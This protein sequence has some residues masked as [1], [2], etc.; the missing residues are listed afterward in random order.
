MPADWQITDGN[1]SASI[2]V[3]AGTM[4]GQV[5]VQAENGCGLSAITSINVIPFASVPAVPVDFSGEL[6]PCAG[7]T[8]TY[9][10]T[11]PTAN[12]VY[13][14]LFPATWVVQSQT[15]TAITVAATSEA[16]TISLSAVNGCGA[17]IA[18]SKAVTPYDGVPTFLSEI[19]GPPQICSGETEVTYRIDPA[20]G[21]DTYFWSVPSGWSIE[22]GQG[23][24]TIKV[25]PGTSGGQITV[26][27]ENT[28]G[29]SVV[30]VRNEVISP[31]AP[32]APTAITGT[33]K[34]CA[35]Q[36]PVTFTAA[37]T[38]NA[39]SYIWTYPADWQ[40]VGAADE[41]T[42]TFTIGSASGE[43]TVKAKNS[44]GASAAT[45]YFVAVVPGKLAAGAIIGP[46]EVCGANNVHTYF[47]TPVT[48]AINYKWTLPAGWDFVSAPNG[49]SVQ[50]RVGG[51]GTIALA[52]ENEC[53][54]GAA[55][56]HS[57]R[58]STAPPASPAA[59]IAG[60]G[61]LNPCEGQTGLTYSVA[62]VA[63]ATSYVWSVP[64]GWTFTGQGSSTI[65]VTSGTGSGQIR[66]QAIN[67]CLPSNPAISLTVSAFGTAPAQ[68]QAVVGES[69]PC[70]GST[71]VIYSVS[72]PVPGIS[73]VWQV[74]AN[75]T[76]T[77]GLGSSQITVTVG[78][79]AGAVSVTASNGCGT[80][81]ATS[82][83]VIPTTG[84]PAIPGN[85]E[86]LKDVC[87]GGVL[88]YKVPASADISNY[89]WSVPLGW[90]I[91]GGSGTNEI[92]VSFKVARTGVIRLVATN[93]CNLAT[94]KELSVVASPVKSDAAPVITGPE[95]LCEGNTYT[96]KVN[97]VANATQY[98]W[99]IPADWEEVSGQG[100]NT[101]VVKIGSSS[102]SVYVLKA[103]AS[104]GCGGSE[105]AVFNTRVFPPGLLSV[106]AVSGPGAVC[107]L[108]DPV[109]FTVPSVPLAATYA[110][111]FPAGWQPVS[112]LNSNT[113]VIIPGTSSGAVTVHVSNPCNVA[114]V[115][116]TQQVT[117][118]G[119][120]PPAPGAILASA[121]ASNPCVAQTNL[122]YSITAIA[123]TTAYEWRY[124]A[125][126]N[127][128]SGGTS[129]STSITLTAGSMVG[130]IAVRAKNECGW[131]GWRTY[132]V[133]PASSVPAT[134]AAIS[135]VQ[136][137]CAGATITY[138]VD[139]PVAQVVYSWSYPA[140]W[141]L[142]SGEGTSEAVFTVGTTSGNVSVTASN[143]CGLSPGAAMLPVAPRAGKPV[144]AGPINGD[145]T[146]CAGI[147]R[148]YAVTPVSAADSYEWS[149]PAGWG[150]VGDDTSS[151]ITVTVGGTSGLISVRGKNSCGVGDALTMAV[152][153]V[154]AIPEAPVGITG[155][156]QVC[157]TD[158]TAIFKVS[159]PVAGTTYTWSVP[160]SW[161]IT[162]S[163]GSST[164]TAEIGDTGEV[165]VI[166]SNVCGANNTPATLH[167]T[168][169]TAAPVAAGS[170]GG[171][172]N[173][174]ADNT[175][176][177]YTVPPVNGATSYEWTLPA[178]WISVSGETTNSITVKPN[179]NSGTISV[180]G[181]NS[182][183]YGAAS[184]LAVTITGQAPT[185]PIAIKTTA[186]G[187]APCKDQAGLTY[188]ID[189]VV[190]AV[191]YEWIYP[192]D[193]VRTA[194]GTASSTSIT[195]TAGAAS[196]EVKVTAKGSGGCGV[197]TASLAVTIS[198]VPPVAPVAINGDGNPCVGSQQKYRVQNPV[199]GMTYN[200]V[201]PGSDWVTVTGEGSAEITVT[202]GTSAGN[203]SVTAENG[204]GVSTAITK[205]VAPSV[206]TAPL[207]A[208][209]AG[210][211][212]ACAGTVE[213]YT[214]NVL[215]GANSIF[216]DVPSDWSIVSGQGTSTLKV[217]VG[218][219]NGVIK[220]SAKNSCDQSTERAL[221]ITVTN[222]SPA[223]IGAIT[224]TATEVCANGEIEFSVPAVS[225]AT[226][227]KWELPAGASMVGSSSTN[228]VKIR[229][230]TVGGQV[231]VKA[232]NQCGEGPV[233]SLA[234]TVSASGP[235]SIA[236][237]KG[238]R[239]LCG[240]AGSQIYFI[241]P[242][243]RAESYLWKVP[244]AWTVIGDKTGTSIEVQQNGL[245]GTLTVEARNS[246]GLTSQSVNVAFETPV[247]AAPAGIVGN[248]TPCAGQTVTYRISAAVPGATS[249]VWSVPSGW[250]IIGDDKGASIEVTAGTSGGVVAVAGRNACA[251]GPEAS[252]AVTS[253]GA[254]PAKPAGVI[255]TA[256]PCS[257]SEQT[258]KIDSPVAG[259]VYTWAY[260][261]EWT[262][263]SGQGT[264]QL[265]VNIGAASGN[266]SV[267]ASFAGG[268]DTSAPVTVAVSNSSNA[269]AITSAITGSAS[270]CGGASTAVAY[271]VTLSAGAKDID[272]EVP[273][274]WNIVSGE[275]AATLQV[276]PGS[277]GGV[278]KVSALNACGDRTEK[279]LAVAVSST[280]PS[281]LSAITG[282]A[283][284]C[285][286]EVIA[287]SVPAVANADEYIWTLPAEATIE[288]GE[289]SNAITV[290]LGTVGGQ[291]SVY[292]KN[293]CGASVPV[294]RTINTPKAGPDAVGAIAGKTTVCAQGANQTY[295]I[296]PVNGA[297]DYKWSV[298][299]GWTQ[300]SGGNGT[301]SITLT[302]GNTG[303]IVSVQA[304]NASTNCLPTTTA[305]AITVAPQISKTISAIE[306]TAVPCVGSVVTYRV[307]AVAGAEKY[308]WLLPLGWKP[309]GDATGASIQVEVGSNSGSVSVYASA[310][311]GGD[312]NW[313]SLNVTP[314]DGVPTAPA[315]IIG[316]ASSCA[317]STQVYKVLNPEAGITYNWTL[318]G[319]DWSAVNGTGSSEIT[320][321]VGSTPGTISVTATNTCNLA[322][323]ATFKAVGVLNGTP[324]LSGAISG[325]AN[326]CEGTTRLYSITAAAE[327]QDIFWEV[328][329]GW[330]VVS[331]GTASV[332]ITAGATGGIIKVTAKNGCGQPVVKTLA[333]TG[334]PVLPTVVGPI[335]GN[336]AGCANEVL[337]FSV[338]EPEGATD[339]FWE[340][341]AGATLRGGEGTH[342]ITAQMGSVSGDIKVTIFDNCGNFKELTHSIELSTSPPVAI[343]PLV[344]GEISLCST[345][346]LDKTYAINAVTGAK[347]YKWVY[348]DAWTYV[349]GQGTTSITLRTNGVSGALTV[350]ASNSCDTQTR[351]WAVKVEDPITTAPGAIAGK[352]F[353]CFNEGNL[354][355]SVTPITGV[356]YIWEVTGDLVITSGGNSEK[357]TIKT[358]AAG[359]Q[360]SVKVANATC[361][362]GPAS[363]VTV[364]PTGTAPTPPAG[365][366]GDANPCVGT[367]RTYSVQ[368]PVPG[369]TYR[370]SYPAGWGPVT[371]QQGTDKLTVTIGAT[372]GNIEV[373]AEGCLNSTAT[374]F[375]VTPVNGAPVL[376]ANIQGQTTLCPNSTQVE[377]SIAG[378]ATV[379]DWNVPTGWSITENLGN[380][381]KVST[382]N[383]GGVVTVTASN[384]CGQTVKTLAVAI[385]TTAPDALASILGP[386]RVCANTEAVYEVPVA[387]GATSYTW[388][389]PSG[390]SPIGPVDSN[391]IRILMGSASGQVTVKAA[392][393]C[394]FTTS[395]VV[396][397]VTV[398]Q[399][400][401][402]TVGAI[403]GDP[404][405]FCASSNQRQYYIDPVTG[406][407]RYKWT[408]PNGWTIVGPDNTETLTVVPG[409]TGGDLK[410]EA[411]NACGATNR[412]IAVTVVQPLAGISEIAGSKTPCVNQEVTFSVDAVAGVGA[413][414]Y[415][416]TY[417]TGWIPVGPVNGRSIVLRT[418]A[419]PGTVSVSVANLC[420]NATKTMNVVPAGT[421]PAGPDGI[422][423]TVSVC[424]GSRGVK[425]TVQNPIAG[426]RYEWQLSAGSDWQFASAQGS[427]EMAF[428][429]GAV[430]TTVSVRAV[431]CSQSAAATRAV[432]V[433]P[434]V[435]V[436]DRIINE[437]DVCAGYKFSVAPIAGAGEYVWTVPAGWKINGQGSASV[438]LESPGPITS[439][440]QIAVV[441]KSA[442]GVCTSN[443]LTF[444][445][446]PGQ[447]GIEDELKV[448]NA[449]SPNNDGKN[450]RWTVNGLMNYPDNELVVI[451]RW[452]SEVFRQKGY[453]NNWDG[454]GLAEGTYFYILKV[455]LCDNREV[456]Y[457]GYL[458]LTR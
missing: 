413:T 285:V 336:T 145:K 43:V 8:Y 384:D 143:G 303:G 57:T 236:D 436:L 161:T 320:V 243:A 100:T 419:T 189:P 370:W 86:G 48:G 17:G 199:V 324:A 341:P 286:K 30:K 268:C 41:R 103:K 6:K 69:V 225:G 457:K 256:T 136:D 92:T 262:Y 424:A 168:V 367:S 411:I 197:I 377:Y 223:T 242:V 175:T 345:D 83:G 396:K 117:V 52:I 325:S 228:A 15:A 329:A 72:N 332:Q 355:Y 240:T 409:A 148:T 343:G 93:G 212:K 410:V 375:A 121:F 187:L 455:R 404:A 427:S 279:A 180:R 374:T 244:A 140:G 190:G 62:P 177:I 111:T 4:A 456:T 360:L 454:K 19:Q 104:N 450:E 71:G 160:A 10:V 115:T 154:P 195:L 85:I 246:C 110:W 288:S 213:I 7:Q 435:G 226:S 239:L 304:L 46:E 188:S 261:S 334:V 2:T 255:T 184:T 118:V 82:L 248:F 76:I 66:V 193:W 26:K 389:W 79:G 430:T 386:D 217:T 428:N 9:Q 124:P 159:S 90:E 323:A 378:T 49:A 123:G 53:G 313:A 116:S 183:G 222:G 446:E 163:Q 307:N 337:T 308:T 102:G 434:S 271:A 3:K 39:S 150:I 437:T 141:L 58:V 95:D 333:V 350:E 87:R 174:C 353:P 127:V 68:P 25:T 412:T 65:T 59:I 119:A 97:D 105:E 215:A 94:V 297:T 431:S 265:V 89:E 405:E 368:S 135:G 132:T 37:A 125:D 67:A 139:S 218:T 108:G 335:T 257:N 44:C 14:W 167:V 114:A 354:E 449:F 278:I 282:P 233:A 438:T 151:T 210:S 371:G 178:G 203:I 330:R 185:G 452:G 64:T 392:N 63:G 259:V 113:L 28:C 186:A 179:A 109:T 204:C 70:V 21:A 254:A 357:V 107:A 376:A 372:A 448:Y 294:T 164:L 152:E 365:I 267:T 327:A 417:P 379:W 356:Q 149:L 338:P 207:G 206:G 432:T 352:L 260:P 458:M 275:N 196:G 169:F 290:K 398:T 5:T 415:S 301:T 296:A 38:A 283:D 235:A 216:W 414:G 347:E 346:A 298:P 406:A 252:V 157:S 422:E 13:T 342:E 18:Q 205:Q 316:L 344:A 359:G 420:S 146:A 388:T 27:A 191:E 54:L 42:I 91:V 429:V 31:A 129:T 209:I 50:V 258:F 88:T 170:I 156:T 441:A 273:A 284:G 166:A 229:F 224:A 73:Y 264:S 349:A 130:E 274:G 276:I 23:T 453:K 77:A 47:V 202:A 200:W 220:V 80:S 214:I 397:N 407:D 358:G 40:V 383:Q 60:P 98:I 317:G 221:A 300:V 172:N 439:P 232:A 155:A 445:V 351:S 120:V 340:L 56:T 165:S 133:T 443:T 198:T 319:A 310:E 403:K 16:G 366:A 11:S 390:A 322:S 34:L 312:S 81:V 369:M 138:K 29:E 381:I 423:G 96:F 269:P 84:P 234:V 299:A 331:N 321:V 306:G 126:W 112:G 106:G 122:T 176:K 32:L 401:P 153:G 402:N 144:L 247:T 61:A 45:S 231:R 128:T 227:Y 131:G 137:P 418:T 395:T 134:P 305:V 253:S 293:G 408:V 250:N 394:G 421:V 315:G 281:A 241:D 287:F 24:A 361:G 272:W 277:T 173:Y 142:I 51:T 328:P 249:Y 364:T 201:L 295:S 362:P 440:V 162:S 35:G 270:V 426:M 425:Y 1:G 391:K 75:W 33:A 99:N 442:N 363:V 147:T 55:S 74:P 211:D 237:I 208:S 263:V 291:I 400:A 192:S 101:L 292:A 393:S 22:D 451:N 230:G 245:A 385:A 280:V 311:C 194:G 387:N 380:S 266:V 433:T 447:V 36:T 326:P 373:Y 318:P 302:P 219:G 314:V 158:N 399:G 289:G 416:W 348:P 78:S 251:P 444:D 182:C 382:N 20:V 339:Y 181:R 171:D 309:V 12:V 238:Q